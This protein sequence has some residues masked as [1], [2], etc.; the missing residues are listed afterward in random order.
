M[1]R[2]GNRW[3]AGWLLMS[4]SAS[5]FAWG[6]Q[7]HRMVALIAADHLT[8]VAAAQVHELLGSETM[9]DVASWADDV[10]S[11]KPETAGWHYVDIP[12]AEK[13]YL[14]ERDCPLPKGASSTDATV[15]RDC[16]ADRIL[17]FE[18]VLKN[19][20]NPRAQRVDALKFLIHLI[21]DIHQPLHAIGDARGGNSIKII[22]FGTQQCAERQTCNLHGAWDYGL[23]EHKRLSEEKYV[24]GLEAEITALKLTEKPIGNPI[25]W[26]NASH[27]AAV[28]AWVPNGGVVGKDYY[29][30]EIPVLDRELEFGGLHLANVLNTLL[31]AAPKREGAPVLL[32]RPEQKDQAK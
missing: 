14:R 17:Y 21:G 22:L 23:I 10:R 3:L 24:A 25:S 6:R 11:E 18:G 20:E 7:G 29:D 1:K 27:R 26:T 31:V 16:A 2:N 9:A 32:P 5:A 8:P 13:T 15:W 28:E 12:M 4:M 30:A 19:P